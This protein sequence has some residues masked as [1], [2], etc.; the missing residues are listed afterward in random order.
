M[1]KRTNIEM[2]RFPNNARSTMIID[3][4][5]HALNKDRY[6]IRKRGR[7]PNRELT[8]EKY[9]DAP[10]LKFSKEIAVYIE[11]KNNYIR[12]MYTDYK[13]EIER[14]NNKVIEL[15]KDKKL[16]MEIIDNQE[17]I[18]KEKETCNC[19]DTLNKIRVLVN[20]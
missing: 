5:V 1:N 4:M 6:K 19:N 3:N 17:K 11:D 2:F 12:F 9:N 18:L 13:E 16:L 20:G 15:N 14:L 7:K 10:P 8:Q